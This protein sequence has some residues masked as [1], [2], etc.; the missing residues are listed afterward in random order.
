[1]KS[2]IIAITTYFLVL[3]GFYVYLTASPCHDGLFIGFC[4]LGRLVTAVFEISWFILA[5]LLAFF[6]KKEKA[7]EKAGSRLI[8]YAVCFALGFM[9]L[10]A[11]IPVLAFFSF[12]FQQVVG[13]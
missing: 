8:H 5:S 3:G 1:M 11:P 10:L 2:R 7:Q 12:L 9:L 4:G 13:F 6:W